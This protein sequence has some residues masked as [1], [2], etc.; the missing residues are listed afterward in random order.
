MKQGKNVSFVDGE[1][2]N[3]NGVGDETDTTSDENSELCY[4]SKSKIP[5]SCVTQ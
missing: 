5:Y 3:E 4:K 1:Y 2:R